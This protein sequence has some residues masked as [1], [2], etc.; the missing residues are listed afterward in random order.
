[1]NY[2]QRFVTL[3]G[4]QGSRPAP[5]E[6]HEKKAQ[7]LSEEALQIAVERREVK[8]KG[9][10]ER[11]T[12]LNA[13]FQRIARRHKKAF[14]SDQCKEIEETRE[15]ERIEISS[16]KLDSKQTFHTKMGSIK[17]R[18]GMDLTEVGDIKKMWQEYTEELY[19]KDLHDPDNHNG[20]V[21]HTHLEP[22]ILECKVK[23][24]LGSITTNKA[25]GGDGMP[26]GL[27]QMLKDDAVKVLHSIC[28]QIWRTQQ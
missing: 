15:W 20:V 21:T 3:Y 25:S 12:H 27:F 9:E 14:L 28:Q 8:S 2:G 16:R 23:W 5:W 13:E 19:K 24:T 22:G 17:D 7:W 10:K 11:Y 1:M 18:N 26:V 6:K 4:R